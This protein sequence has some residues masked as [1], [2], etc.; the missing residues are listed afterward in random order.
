M[1]SQ[2]SGPEL[3]AA[4]ARIA[5]M[6]L[7]GAAVSA[8]SPLVRTLPLEALTPVKQLL[9]R[10]FSEQPWTEDDDEALA[11]LVGAPAVPDAGTERSELAPGLVLVWGWAGGRFRLRVQDGDGPTDDGDALGAL[12]G[13]VVVP[14]ATPRCTSRRRRS[15]RVPA[16][17]SRR[18]TPL[19]T[20][21]CS[22]SSRSART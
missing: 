12:F 11:D 2:D 8:L 19:T 7:T 10:Y 16:G 20:S 17:R 3:D 13:G 14:E 5:G 6:E 4:R 15:G 22:S 18:R 1:T 21:R 9:K